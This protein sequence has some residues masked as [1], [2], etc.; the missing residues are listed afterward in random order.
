MRPPKPMLGV[1]LGKKDLYVHMPAAQR[2][3]GA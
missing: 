2:A 3:A 1:K